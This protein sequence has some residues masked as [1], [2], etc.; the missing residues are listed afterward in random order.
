MTNVAICWII[1]KSKTIRQM[2]VFVNC[3]S[4]FVDDENA[5]RLQHGHIIQTNDC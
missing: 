5:Q 4:V 2:A 3:R 1:K